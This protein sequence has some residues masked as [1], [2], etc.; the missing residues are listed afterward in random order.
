MKKTAKRII[1]LVLCF[2]MLAGV[3]A[4][5]VSAE[6][7]YNYVSLGD[8]TSMG[9]LL[10]DYAYGDREI[11]GSCKYS[12]FSMMKNYLEE[13][14]K[15]NNVN[16]KDLTLLGARPIEL[17]AI[18]DEDYS[19][20][21]CDGS[22]STNLGYCDHHI[23]QY[24]QTFTSGKS[25]E[26]LHDLYVNA[27]ANADLITFDLIMADTKSLFG[28]FSNPTKYF[29]C[30]SYA[31]ML[32]VE[33]HPVLADIAE[34]L[35]ATL[36]KTLG[37]LGLPAEE[38][39]SFIDG[40]QRIF[41]GLCSNYSDVM[42]L[43]YK[44]NPDVNMIVVG[45]YNAFDGLC[46]SVGGIEIELGTIWGIVQSFIENYAISVDKHCWRYRYADCPDS[47]GLLQQSL[48]NGDFEQYSYV[49]DTLL[50]QLLG[51]NYTTEYDA[52]KIGQVKSAL[53]RACSIRTMPIDVMLNG[54][55]DY[56]K[57]VFSDSPAEEDYAALG[58]EVLQGLANSAG[59]HPNEQGYVQKFESVKR[60]F[61]SPV[62]ANGT[63]LT[64][65]IDGSVGI[66]NNVV[67]AV[68]GNRD[69]IMRIITV[70]KNIFTPIF[71]LPSIFG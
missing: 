13:T 9:Y 5:G 19:A 31:E 22:S 34:D 2:V 63:H 50:K 39:A 32:S 7:S 23:D 46:V 57:A 71:R 53:S 49:T 36:N 35:R 37:G 30:E 55:G 61:I 44:L 56:T 48:A 28:A 10:N 38:L 17:R 21:Y 58:W 18:L 67:G 15:L 68:F 54:A 26:E 40:V 60:A 11:K 29:N 45:P 51:K 14:W 66:V 70:I 6:E 47:I 27:I 4:V 8:S 42:D 33:G 59:I 65:I 52:A 24:I 16:A 43:I 64:R 20:L 12:V 69:S 62:A 1:S 25:Y 3:F 41:Y